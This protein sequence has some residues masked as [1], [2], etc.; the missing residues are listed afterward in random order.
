MPKLSDNQAVL[1]A[2]SAA[3]PDL[4]VLPVPATLKLKGAALERSL[5]AMLDR[6]LIA[7]AA[8]TEPAAMNGADGEQERLV[9]TPAGLDDHRCREPERR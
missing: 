3:R 8:T 6:G 2:A 4:S 5:R 9:V 1:L 7:K